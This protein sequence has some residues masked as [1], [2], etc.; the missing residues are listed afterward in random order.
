LGWF[1]HPLF[2]KDIDSDEITLSKGIFVVNLFDLPIQKPPFYDKTRMNN[3]LLGYS[4][5]E[6]FD[7]VEELQMFDLSAK[8][9]KD[10]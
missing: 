10:N 5:N 3:L 4:L 2:V 7:L 1:F 9:K 6:K 8:V